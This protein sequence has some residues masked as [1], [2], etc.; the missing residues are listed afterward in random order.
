MYECCFLLIGVAVICAVSKMF[1]LPCGWSNS[2]PP[3]LLSGCTPGAGGMLEYY[4]GFAVFYSWC[5]LPIGC[6]WAAATGLMM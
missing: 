4:S 6:R 3:V 5:S 2:L 1:V